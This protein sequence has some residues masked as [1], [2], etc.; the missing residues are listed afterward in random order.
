MLNRISEARC[1]F[2]SMDRQTEVWGC[3]THE[4]QNRV[5]VNLSQGFWTM[6]MT[7]PWTPIMFSTHFV[8]RE[9][10]SCLTLGTG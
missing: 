1:Y 9:S 8:E 5:Q 7:P 10:L 2:Y 4:Q 3:W 6:A